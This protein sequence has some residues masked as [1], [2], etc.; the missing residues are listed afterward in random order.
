[1]LHSA[2]LPVY[3]HLNVHGYWLMRDTK[4]SKSLGNV[5]HPERMIELFGSDAF[6]YFML[7]EMHFGSDAN[8]NYDAL[9]TRI[10][11]RSTTRI[12]PTRTAT[13]SAAC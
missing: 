11:S 2:G 9:I 10:N 6:R 3:Q 8:F 12:W 4:M 1:M 13:C 7:A 5:V